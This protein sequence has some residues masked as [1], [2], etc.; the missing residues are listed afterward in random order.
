MIHGILYNIKRFY[1]SSVQP[2]TKGAAE[3]VLQVHQ[4]QSHVVISVE[5]FD[6]IN[7]Y[8]TGPGVGIGLEKFSTVNI[9]LLVAVTSEE[10]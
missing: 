7:V 5:T 9:T 10:D 6:F 1:S 3:T 2:V 4:H 8:F